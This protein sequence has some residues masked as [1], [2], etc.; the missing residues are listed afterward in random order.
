MKHSVKI[1][2]LPLLV[3]TILISSCDL[4]NKNGN[5]DLPS[6]PQPL[7]EDTKWTM[8]AFEPTSGDRL[9]IDSTKTWPYLIY[10]NTDST[11][12]AQ[13]YCNG[14]GGEFNSN[15]E[16]SSINIFSWG[17]TRSKCG[18]TVTFSDIMRSAHLYEVKD[19]YLY[20]Y[21]SEAEYVLY[22]PEREEYEG[23][24]EGRAIFRKGLGRYD[25]WLE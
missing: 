9:E 16:Q 19:E 25:D 2:I 7:L 18:W 12:K 21:Y 23:S 10:F 6:G 4:L 1:L 8:I 17:G 11:I 22:S 3:I 15:Y 24:K 13:S 5:S 14:L 20:L